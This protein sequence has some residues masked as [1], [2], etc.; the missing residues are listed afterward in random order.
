MKRTWWKLVSILAVLTIVAAACG[1]D[2]GGDSNGSGGD[3]DTTEAADL[4]GD[5]NE[6]VRNDPLVGPEGSGLTRG[7]TDASITIGCVVEAANYTGAEDGYNA[8][9]ERANRDGGIHGRQ[10]EF[11]G[12]ADDGSDPQQNLQLA[13]GLVEQDEVFALTNLSASALPGT[14]DFLTENEVPYVGWGFSPGFCGHRWGFGFNGCLIGDSLPDLVPH[15][16][17]AG[18]LADAIIEATGMDPE[19]VR[20]AFQAGDD[21]AG[22]AGNQQYEAVFEDRGAEVVYSEAN[23]P[24]PGPTSDYTPFVQEVLAAEPNIVLTSTQFADVGGFSGSLTAAGYEG[25]NQ[26]FVAYV[27]GLLQSSE[28]LADALQGTYV[29]SQIVPQESQ[30]EYIQQVEQDLEAV[31]AEQGSFILLGAGLGYAQA[32]ML[33]AMLEAAGPDLNTQTF[34][35]AVNG[36]DFVYE[37]PFEGGPGAVAFPDGHFLPA[38]CAAIV[39]VEGDQFNEVVPF[40][41]YESLRIR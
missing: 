36:G 32:D 39:Q 27:P 38:D 5:I 3:T 9:F 29:S 17:A 18:S 33:V 25:A 22:R 24:V 13:R 28:Q 12:C 10:I 26:N 6:L 23:I 16:V 35:E 14:T 8:R 19:E 40:D 30:T 15:A 2:D 1:D 20:V 37:S 21:D 34:D 4:S 11:L 41:C 7:V 31:N